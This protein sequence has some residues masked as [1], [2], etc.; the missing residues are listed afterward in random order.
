MKDLFVVT[1]TQSIH[2]VENKVGGWYDTGLTPRGEIDARATAER[3]AGMV[4]GSDAEIF[5][6]DLLRASQSA[7]II[8]KRLQQP[9]VHTADLR[10]I[11][12][13]SAGGKPNDWLAARQTPAPDDNRMDHRGVLRMRKPAEI[14]R[15][16][17]TGA[18]SPSSSARAK[19]KSS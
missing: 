13:G 14:L 12:Y 17:F 11:R 2:H 7:A 3:L 18:W 4:G 8:A 15:A 10:E 9:V 6:S 16:V 1:H 19:G 5:S